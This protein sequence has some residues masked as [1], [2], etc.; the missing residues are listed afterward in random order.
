MKLLQLYIQGQRVDLFN[1]ESVTITDSIQNVKDI[2]KIFTSFSQSFSVPASKTNNKIFKHYYNYDITN[3]FDARVKVTARIEINYQTFKTGK[4]KLQGVDLKNNKPHTYR[5][6]FFGDI[7]ELKDK[8]GERK[9]SSLNNL[10][11]LNLDY[12]W[13]TVYSKLTADP[14][15]TDVI[16]PLITH[17]QRLYYDSVSHNNTDDG[18]LYYHNGAHYH[19]VY[20]N[21]L[22]YALRVNRL[23]EAIEDQYD[24]Q[25]STDFF[26]NASVEEMNNMFMWLH[27]KSGKVEDLSGGT[28][29]T[30]L[31]TGWTYVKRDPYEMY[32]A[33]LFLLGDPQSFTRLEL[34]IVP[35][36]QSDT[37]GVIVQ[38]YGETV[39]ENLNVQ[40]S[41]LGIDLLDT[42]TNYPYYEIYIVSTGVVAFNNIKWTIEYV[43]DSDPFNTYSYFDTFSNATFSTGGVFVFNI[44][45]Q[46]PDIKIIDF[47]SGL[48]KMFNLT[49]YVENGIIVVKKLDDFY[50]SSTTE[51]DI[52]KYVEQNN[53]KVDAA[54]PYKE[55]ILKF[56]DTSYFLAEKFNQLNNKP[57]GELLYNQGLTD[58]AGGLYKVEIP[59]GHM[60]FERLTDA[61]TGTTKNIQYG[62]CVNESQN[63]Y[64]GAPLMFYPIRVNTGVISFVKSFNNDGNPNGHTSITNVNLPFNSVSLNSATNNFNLNFYNEFSE[65]TT[66]ST[67]TGTLFQNYYSNYIVNTFSLKQRITKVTAYLPL[68]ILLNYNLSDNFIINGFSYK[69]NSIT[70]NLKNGKSELELLNEI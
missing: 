6:T 5:I 45:R 13:T 16:A 35:T 21:E 27:R 31:V 9:L 10:S 49:A 3:T 1:D 58:L 28:E 33:S 25:F 66:D 65:W 2:E 23:I 26:R 63:A 52:T 68:R 4:I 56:K 54:L 7:V 61:G 64:L 69:I 53:S 14:T 32:N 34:D 18:N 57:W 60:L 46:M 37:Y 22:K 43:D 8:L 11:S 62:Y 38:V 42:I 19:G 15:T 51:W 67:F 24:L 70:T 36:S 20:W 59:F 40:G 50:A 12:E 55:I 17:S 29:N 30:E 41:L 47:L 39:Y 44:N 48:F